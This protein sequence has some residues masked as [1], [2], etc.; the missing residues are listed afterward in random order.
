MDLTGEIEIK[1]EGSVG[2]QQLSPTLVDIEEIKEI[3][4]QTAHLLFPME[5]RAQRPL[6]SYQISEG[7]VRHQFRTLMQTVIGLGAVLGQINAANQIDFLHER[8]AVAI[9][10]LQQLAWEKNYTITV[11]AHDQRLLI[12]KNT[13]FV[14]DEQFWVEAEFYLYGEL[15]DAGGKNNPNIH[16]D[17]EDY[18]ILNI[19][20]D[21]EFLKKSEENLLYKKFG[22]RVLGKQNLQTFEM[23]RGSLVFVELFDYNTAYSDEYLDKLAQKASLAWQGI[24]NVDEWLNTVRHGAYA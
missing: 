23:D 22:L 21:K 8:S 17:T 14:R 16:L 1:I 9:E 2:A 10:K 5:K 4:I 18:G 19:A 15:V 13:R 24:A 11:Q 3:L 7:S 20:V 6:I 12:S